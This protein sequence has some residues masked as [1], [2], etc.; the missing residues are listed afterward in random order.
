MKVLVLHSHNKLS[1]PHTRD[2]QLHHFAM[3]KILSI[4]GGGIRGIIPAML[5]AEIERRTQKP[6][7][8]LFDLIAGT[9]TGGILA[10]GLVKPDAAGKPQYSAEKMVALYETEGAKIFS[11]SL[12]H[13]VRAIGHFVEEKYLTDGIEAVLEK[14]FGQTHLKE[15]LIEI[16]I[17]SYEIEQNF[18]FFFKSRRAKMESSYD[19]PMQ[20]V[21]RA[22][23]AAP[24]YFE[25]LQ[26]ATIDPATY[27]ALIDGGVYANNPAMCGFAEAKTTHP[28]AEDILMVSLGT[29]ELSRPLLYE[30][31]K[32]WGLVQWA[33]P[34]LDVVFHGVNVTV[35]Y[36]M[37]QLLPP[38]NSERRYFR[39]QTTLPPENNDLD[40]A[41]PENLRALKI[42]AEALIR[43][44]SDTIDMMCQQLRQ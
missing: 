17:T 32:T 22:T 20:Q 4:D 14:Y 34:I 11:R 39:F 40:D 26:L 5:L 1:I 15:A 35:D 30:K 28:E 38:R 19:Y 36:Q 2:G 10:L 9:S 24:T 12:L 23:S 37:R 43:E 13:E 27:F 41:S 6:I 3:I 44:Q 29:G 25:V 42:L 16:I 31:A 8:R 33:K 18:P 7:A 21:A